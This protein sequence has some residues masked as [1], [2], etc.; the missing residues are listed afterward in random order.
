[1]RIGPIGRLAHLAIGLLLAGQLPD[2]AAQPPGG[3]RKTVRIVRTA[4]PPVIDGRLDEEVW[5]Q[6]AIVDDLHQILPTEYASPSEPTEVLLLYDSDALYVAARM[7]HSDPDSMTANVL[8]QGEVFWG[9]DL[10]SVILD[11]FDD[12]RSG[13]RFQV[14]PNGIRMQ[15]LY[16]DTTHQLWDWNGIWDAAATQNNDGWVAEIAIP[17][18]TLSF[19]PNNDTWGINFRRDLG[20]ADERIGWVSYNRTQDP[21]NEGEVV[22]LAGLDV[23]RGLDVVP[24]LSLREN[25][26]FASAATNFDPQPSLDL[27]YKISPSL[28]G[29]LT[30]NTDFSATEVDDRQV[31]LTRFNL[32]FPEK[33]DFFLRDSDIFR[34]G[35]LG[36]IPGGG[37]SAPGS[38]PRPTLENG[39]PFFS[40]SIG[41]SAT[42]EQVGL[43]Y[44]GKLSGRVGRWDVGMLAIR[45]D[46]FQDVAASDL[47]VGRVAAN[48]L[49]ESSVGIIITNG[50]PRSNLSNS[51]FG[52]DFRYFNSRLPGGR[53]LEGE[54]WLQQSR[55]EGIE[56]NDGAWGLRLRSPNTN[57]FR[58]GLGVKELQENFNPAMGYVNRRGIRDSTAEIGYTLRPRAP[59]V[60]SI[61]SGVDA[62]RID[63]LDGALQTQVVTLRLLEMDNNT[64]DRLRLRY[65]ASKEALQEPFEISE[66][67]VLPTGQY[68]F[69]ETELE[70]R[71]G[72]QRKVFGNFVYRTGDFYDGRRLGLSGQLGWRPSKH[73]RTTIDYS[74]NEV[75]LPEG[76]F[77]TRLIQL[78]TDLI[79]SATL[80]WVTLIQYDNVSDTAGINSR[81]HWVPQA[82]REA[83]VVLNHNLIDTAEDL[84]FRS[85]TADL[86]LKYNYT[87]RF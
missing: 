39:Q 57:G 53:T 74:V 47:L 28:N 44:G 65:Y 83:Y 50:D 87:F 32:F 64:R 7:P 25:K 60:R 13:Y 29:S 15:A 41:L 18:K 43:D 68:E 24:S 23:G 61:Y 45:Q 51:V 62:Q 20:A 86:T 70:I 71:G 38:F 81:L 72:P 2:A 10:F 17:F 63:V 16:Q 58:G 55:T 34:F 27:F 56:G 11:P 33:R 75:E 14:N 76:D 22:G 30:I 1:M 46:A 66:G 79:F 6:A 19:D 80:S 67:V 37:G 31:N 48:V 59:R 21:S 52:T 5:Q 69:G 73:F 42:G 36:V 85:Q 49:P 82:G 12:Q 78:R 3:E 9:D 40:R 77:T 26:D 4:T 8:R 54:A 84:S 35:R